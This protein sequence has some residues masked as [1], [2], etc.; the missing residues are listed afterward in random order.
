MLD[1]L[2]TESRRWRTRILGTYQLRQSFDRTYSYLDGNRIDAKKWFRNCGSIRAA[3]WGTRAAFHRFRADLSGVIEQ[4]VDLQVL[5]LRGEPITVGNYDYKTRF[6][7]G[8]EVG[9]R[10]RL[11]VPQRIRSGES[12]PA[13]T[14]AAIGKPPPPS[15]APVP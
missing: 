10:W 3:A 7:L 6:Y 1:F 5:S 11:Y 4:S 12:V 15:T 9:T 2:F 13:W 8:N 14:C